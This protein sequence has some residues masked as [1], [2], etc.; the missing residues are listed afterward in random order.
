MLVIMQ[1]H[2]N[3][4]V[5]AMENKFMKPN[6]ITYAT[7]AIGYSRSRDLDLAE[8]M[9]DRMVDEEPQYTHAFNSLFT[10]CRAVDEPG[11]ALR[12]LA[13]M[14]HAKVKPNIRCELRFVTWLQLQGFSM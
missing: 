8:S 7:L 13:R 1:H 14:R 3:V 11:R 10:A 6:N 12:V 4:Q 9:L 2:V 5:K